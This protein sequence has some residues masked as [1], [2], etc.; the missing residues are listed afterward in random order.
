LPEI[1]SDDEVKQMNEYMLLAIEEAK[2]AKAAGKVFVLNKIHA[3]VVD[4]IPVLLAA[5][6][7]CHRQ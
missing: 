1:F 5:R 2:K 6:G 3:K 4:P 7:V